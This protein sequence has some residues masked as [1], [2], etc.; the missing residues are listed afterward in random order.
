MK[1]IEE[2]AGNLSTLSSQMDEIKNRLDEY[3]GNLHRSADEN[4]Q[5][6]DQWMRMSEEQKDELFDEAIVEFE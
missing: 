5:E 2:V 4:L 6:G 1:Q 3:E